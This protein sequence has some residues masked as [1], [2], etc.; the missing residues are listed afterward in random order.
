MESHFEALLSME[1]DHPVH[2]TSQRLGLSE[3]QAMFHLLFTPGDSFVRDFVL[4]KSSNFPQTTHTEILDKG[5]GG[6]GKGKQSKCSRISCFTSIQIC[7]VQC[8]K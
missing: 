7:S 2:K 1:S 3:R 8:F 6:G 4:N 5:G